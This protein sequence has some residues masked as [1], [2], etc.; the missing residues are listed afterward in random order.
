MVGEQMVK[1]GTLSPEI[2]MWL[3]TIILVPF[4]MVL[5]Y[6]SIKGGRKHLQ[7]PPSI[8]TSSKKQSR[9]DAHPATMS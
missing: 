7:F 3:S 6:F 9:K 8:F 2:G 5:T 4:A 1:S